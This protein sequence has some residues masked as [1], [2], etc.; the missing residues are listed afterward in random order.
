M[1]SM[2]LITIGCESPKQKSKLDPEVKQVVE[3]VFGEPDIYFDDALVNF[4]ANDMAAAGQNLDE[5]IIFIRSLKLK[6]DSVLAKDLFFTVSELEALRDELLE[7]KVS[8]ESV[9][10]E[11]FGDVDAAIA[12]YHLSIVADHLQS[13]TQDETDME[14][15]ER[16]LLRLDHAATYK[17]YVLSAEEQSEIDQIRASIKA[18]E[19][20]LSIWNRANKLLIKVKDKISNS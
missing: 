11:T 19:Q 7:S 17:G 3:T 9:L 5:A 16:A 2:I 4:A 18:A 12:S 14:R 13:G 1:G 8:E 20:S 15:L 6:E 10:R